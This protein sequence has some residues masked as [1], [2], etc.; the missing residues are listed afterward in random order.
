MGS[1]FYY[2]FGRGEEEY[3]RPEIAKV[4]P[5]VAVGRPGDPLPHLGANRAYLSDDDWQADVLRLLD[6][7]AGAV[8]RIGPGEGLLWE[9]QHAA[10]R[11]P[12]ERLVF[13][14]P[15]DPHLYYWFKE[16]I[17]RHLPRPLPWYPDVEAKNWFQR[18]RQVRF[19]LLGALYL[20]SDWS[21]YFEL[22]TLPT[23]DADIPSA[24]MQAAFAR[25]LHR[26]TWS[27]SR[28]GSP[29]GGERAQGGLPVVRFH[30]PPNWPPPP[31]GWFPPAGWQPDPTWPPA[32][33]NWQ[34]WISASE[35][36]SA[37]VDTDPR[38]HT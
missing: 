38:P 34:F 31:P 1:S 2:D 4:G 14:V 6:R 18:G 15:R 35:V 16:Q 9:T 29:I 17:D 11:L 28:T 24:T 7:A 25:C 12:P 33:P 10:A 8:I 23:G 21:G 37:P 26:F 13:L 30:P 27:L 36:A 32:P 5:F 22:F 20:A 19:Q 3:L